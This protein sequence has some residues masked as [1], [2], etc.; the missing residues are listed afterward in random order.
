[1]WTPSEF[2]KRWAEQMVSVLRDGAVWALP[3][4]STVYKISKERKTLALVEGPK[5]Y[6]FDRTVAT[7]A[8]VGYTVTDERQLAT[9]GT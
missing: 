2:D 1:M 7:F 3:G 6:L 5:D 8:A 4:N 9:H